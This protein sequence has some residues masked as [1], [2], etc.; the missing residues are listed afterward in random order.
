[1]IHYS[2]ESFYDRPSGASPRITSIAVRRLGSGQT[3]SFS[4]HQVAERHGHDLEK[5]DPSY[6]T[7]ERQMLEEYFSFV[8]RVI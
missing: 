5:I 1:V 2:C 8:D 3:T 7:F 6:D 4:I